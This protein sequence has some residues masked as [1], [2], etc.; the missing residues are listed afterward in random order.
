[1]WI[2]N[3]YHLQSS[4]SLK[5]SCENLIWSNIGTGLANTGLPQKGRKMKSGKVKTQKRKGVEEEASWLF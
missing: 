4:L 2:R 3:I 1:M 5:N